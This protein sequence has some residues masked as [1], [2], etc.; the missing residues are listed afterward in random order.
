MTS[1]SEPIGGEVTLAEPQLIPID[2]ADYA[3]A[4][5]ALAELLRPIVRQIGEGS[6]PT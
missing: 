4:V 6:M 1:E 3:A 2:P 5:E